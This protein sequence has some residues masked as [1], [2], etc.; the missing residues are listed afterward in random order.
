MKPR[1]FQVV[2]ASALLLIGC[3]EK[4]GETV[5]IQFSGTAWDEAQTVGT[6]SDYYIVLENIGSPTLDLDGDLAPD[7]FLVPT[8]CSA[9]VPA[10]C[11]YDFQD[12]T[13]TLGDMPHGYS[14]QLTVRFRSVSGAVLYAGTTTFSNTNSPQTVTVPVV[15]GDV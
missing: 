11:G 13:R 14:Y 1:L 8:S 4:R 15:K 9:S 3:G 5:T 12:G 6:V 10:G 7:L 2:L